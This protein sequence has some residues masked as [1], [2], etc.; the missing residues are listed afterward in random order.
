MGPQHERVLASAE[1][2]KRDPTLRIVHSQGGHAFQV[3]KAPVEAAEA[4]AQPLPASV[5]GQVLL[6]AHGALAALPAPPTLPPGPAASRAL[7]Q[8][9]F[10]LPANGVL[11]S[12]QA[13]LA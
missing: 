9:G 8:L 1:A 2:L 3:A 10:K 7:A 6:G 12:F 4:A 13:V 11:P 5:G